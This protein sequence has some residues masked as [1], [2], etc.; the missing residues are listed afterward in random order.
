[1]GHK[2]VETTCNINN[3][4][5]PGAANEHTVEW[6]FKKFYKEDESLDHEEPSGKP[7][8]VDNNQLRA[9][10]EDVPLTTT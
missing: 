10:I 3:G 4:F 5:D 1:M 7:Q 8:E 6:W 9:I 2:V